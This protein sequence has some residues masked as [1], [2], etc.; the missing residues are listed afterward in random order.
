MASYQAYDPR[1]AQSNVPY[2]NNPHASSRYPPN[3][4]Q[5]RTSS[6][7]LSDDETP[8]VPLKK[9][10]NAAVNIR[11][12]SRTPSP[13]PSEAE[14]LNRT[15]MFD[16]KAMANW[17]FWV[18]KQWTWY[19]VIFVI[20]FIVAILFTVYHEQIVRWLQPPANWMHGLPAGWLIP[21]AIM[22][23]LSFPPLF[24]QEIVGILCG[25]VWG[26]WGGF[27][28]V[29]AGTFLGEL[30]NFYAFKYCCA[31]RGEKLERT[32]IRYGCL[33][34]VV[35]DGGF[36]IAI[37]A[38]YSA[39][40]GHF[41][42]AVFSTCGM[43]VWTFAV[44]AFLSLP[45]QFLTVYLGVALEDSESGQSST[46]DT[47]IKDT[48]IGLTTVVTIVAMWYIY[49]QMNAVK[50]QVIYERRKARQAKTMAAGG[51][52]PYSTPSMLESN[53]SFNPHNSET[54][55]PLNSS[56]GGSAYQQWDKYGRAVGYASDPS[57]SAPVPQRGS[58]RSPITASLHRPQEQRM[59]TAPMSMSERER[60]GYTT[61]PSRLPAQ[62]SGTPRGTSPGQQLPG[63]PF[64]SPPTRLDNPFEDWSVRAPG[65]APVAGMASSQAPAYAPAPA[66]SHTLTQDQF[67]A[68]RIQPPGAL[69]DPNTAPARQQHFPGT[70]PAPGPAAYYGAHHATSASE[71]SLEP[72]TAYE[73]TTSVQS[74]AGSLPPPYSPS[75]LR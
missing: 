32:D 1:H 60:T 40:P 69:Q 67:A 57:I 56:Y 3:T 75:S 41:T 72:Y 18:R 31:A 42:T 13:T 53:T 24:G 54:D 27:A 58:S 73:S 33:A 65:S 34:R 28:I 44:A 62:T 2:A 4:Q 26:L 74:Q 63:S 64:A 9:T 51:A 36:K 16:W 46:K 15:Q 7:S 49:K 55:I 12:I 59:P 17:R 45:K 50:P 19:Y 47:I 8:I 37:I 29:A 68:Y 39:I 35:R 66:P 11:Q 14:E 25:L 52:A 30:A 5:Y 48:V 20:I 10:S 23:V 70:N 43:S 21:I 38:R 61:P 71:A 6:L 22:F